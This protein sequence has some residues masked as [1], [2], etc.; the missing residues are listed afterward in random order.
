MAIRV[1]CEA[2]YRGDQEPVAFWL[3]ERRLVPLA[4]PARRRVKG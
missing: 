4:D 1:E 3:G 2:G